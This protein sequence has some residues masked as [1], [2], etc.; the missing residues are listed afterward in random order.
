MIREAEGRDSLILEP[1]IC[2]VRFPS[3]SAIQQ[4]ELNQI[5][6]RKSATIPVREANPLKNILF[7]SAAF[8]KI[9][10]PYR[11]TLTACEIIY[12]NK[13]IK[14]VKMSGFYLSGLNLTDGAPQLSEWS[15][16]EPLETFLGQDEKIVISEEMKDRC[17]FAVHHL[18]EDFHIA[19]N[20]EDNYDISR[21][22]QNYTGIRWFIIDLP[23]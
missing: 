4:A 10:L 22:P 14:S 2:D 21:N 9:E 1:I 15:T 6:S 20:L 16:S 5:L 8:Q 3:E 11:F 18:D 23:R 19:W 12:E 17:Y 7:A 13:R